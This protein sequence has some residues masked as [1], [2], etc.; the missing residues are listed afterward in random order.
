MDF[1]VEETA[2]KTEIWHQWIKNRIQSYMILEIFLC[3]SVILIFSKLS[4]ISSQN[5][6]TLEL[7]SNF[8]SD[9]FNIK[10]DMDGFK[11]V[12]PNNFAGN[13]HRENENL[14]DVVKDVMKN[15]KMEPLHTQ[16]EKLT[17]NS[18]NIS[19]YRFN[20]ASFVLGASI[21][22]SLSSSTNLNP[23]IGRDQSSLVLIDRTNPPADKA[24]CSNVKETVVTVNLA[25]YIKPT[26]VSYQHSKW[27]GMIPDEVPK[28][29]DVVACLDY[30]CTKWVLLVSD[31]EYKLS[32]FGGLNLEEVCKIKQSTAK[33]GKIQ[34]RFHQNQGNTERTCINLIRVYGEA[35][36]ILKPKERNLEDAKRCSDL[37]W[38]YNHNSFMYN[39]MNKSCIELYSK[40]CCTE[41]PECCDECVISDINGSKIFEGIFL[42]IA[43]FL[44]LIIFF[45][46]IMICAAACMGKFN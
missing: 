20:A 22:T 1:V 37:A 19:T 41:C 39:M 26:A 29:Y 38:N 42:L 13:I 35:D 33:T 12:R 27:K 36:E 15:I 7:I 45:V 31:C 30:T 46:F 9:L 32:E 4:H 18:K 10:T 34:F 14:E 24:W 11:A 17:I 43:S 16:E 25:Q 2:T 21:D 23:L 40:D 3:I 28:K 8:Q 6:R 5:E 44:S